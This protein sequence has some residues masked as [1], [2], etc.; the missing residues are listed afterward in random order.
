[1]QHQL[2]VLAAEFYDLVGKP[3]R[4]NLGRYQSA[5]DR[6]AKI[7]GANNS[8]SKSRLCPDGS[9]PKKDDASAPVGRGT[10][11]NLEAG[12]QRLL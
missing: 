7:D 4:I 1:M 9:R 2:P 8:S 3:F 10:E 6:A 11:P 12:Y 5:L